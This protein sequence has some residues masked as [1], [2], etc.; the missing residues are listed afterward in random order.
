M[1]AAWVSAFPSPK[2]GWGLTVIESNA[3]G[4]PVVA[5][6]SPGLVDSVR[7]GETGLLVR[8]GDPEALAAG[9]GRVLRDEELRRSL[10]NRGLEWAA[11]FEWDRS[12]DEAW[13]VAVA[14]AA[15]GKLP[16]S[17]SETGP[18]GTGDPRRADQ[19][20]A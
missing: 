6:R 16:S 20:T 7:D 2:E 15:G 4:T 10:G 13:Q 14:A 12:A 3:C 1:R 9:L 17:F 11:R 8:H 5:S 19:R 18:S